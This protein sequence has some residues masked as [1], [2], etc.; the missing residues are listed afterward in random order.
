[1]E[2]KRKIKSNQDLITQE[3]KEEGI[4]KLKKIIQKQNK[5][6]K[7]LFSQIK[8]ID[9]TIILGE[10][11]AGK[12]L[13]TN[14]LSGS[15]LEEK[16]YEGSFET[17]I[18]LK[19]GE[20]LYSEI[21]HD[22]NKSKTKKLKLVMNL[23]YNLLDTQGFSDSRGVEYDVGFLF[24]L[25]KIFKICRSLKF[26]FLVNYASIISTKANFLKKILNF[27]Q[28]LFVNKENCKNSIMLLIT[29]Q[30]NL[31]IKDFKKKLFNLFLEEKQSILKNRTFFY[32]PLN[33]KKEG[34]LNRKEF[35]DELNNMNYIEGKNLEI[36]FSLEQE[37]FLGEI[38]RNLKNQITNQSNEFQNI[39]E[40]YENF[41]IFQ[42]SNIKFII[43]I[44]Q[45]I[46]DFFIPILKR[47]E[48]IFFK[49]CELQFYSD[50]E[51]ILEK[52]FKFYKK[53]KF[54]EYSYDDL[55]KY[56]EKIKKSKKTKNDL[57]IKNFEKK[58][59]NENRLK[60]E[61]LK[62]YYDNKLEEQKKIYL[63]KIE[64]VKKIEN[65]KNSNV[66]EKKIREI[67]KNNQN[68]TENLNKSYDNEKKLLKKL[69][70]V[71][72]IILRK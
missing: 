71:G 58:I 59:K 12:S 46:D 38:F 57:N 70:K 69:K 60:I 29:K 24:L 10:T 37:I 18:D 35:M 51:K 7:Y 42:K 43:N 64:E 34:V 53:K 65:D 16:E 9:V 67:L 63:K 25:E 20:T 28:K 11:G 5:E 21:G 49:Y 52:L 55:K 33:L 56:L 47:F 61:N 14:F 48:D 15:D 50:A 54:T 22:Y 17:V 32:D 19:E 3:E 4:K 13:T 40:I 62:K 30:K 41:D 2:T 39:L 31:K 1:M 6:N 66:I 72:N 68:H 23:N 27:I 8:D 44:I 36:S 26:I 45:E